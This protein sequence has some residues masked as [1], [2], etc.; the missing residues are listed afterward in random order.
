QAGMGED[1]NAILVKFLKDFESRFAAMQEE[2]DKQRERLDTL[3]VAESQEEAQKRN[4]LLTKMQDAV[5][6]TREEQEKM[7]QQLAR[8]EKRLESVKSESNFGTVVSVVIFS[9]LFILAMIMR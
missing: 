4:E 7:R 9:S 1:N 8:I 5:R 2:V 6:V 3:G